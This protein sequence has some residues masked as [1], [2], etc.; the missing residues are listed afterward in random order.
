[1]LPVLLPV[2]IIFVHIL[3]IFGKLYKGPTFSKNCKQISLLHSFEKWRARFYGMVVQTLLRLE[4]SGKGITVKNAEIP[5]P[6]DALR[7]LTVR[8]FWKR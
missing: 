4:K 8:K 6:N 5:H 3:N 2:R 7:I 1:M